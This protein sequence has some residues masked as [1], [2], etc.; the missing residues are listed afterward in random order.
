MDTSEAKSAWTGPPT[1]P[2]A[3]VPSA[4][5]SSRLSPSPPPPLR[6]PCLSAR[7]R[8]GSLEASRAVSF[9]R[10]GWPFSPHLCRKTGLQASQ[11]AESPT[12]VQQSGLQGGTEEA[13]GTPFPPPPP[14]PPDPRTHFFL[15]SKSAKT[16]GKVRTQCVFDPCAQARCFGTP[17]VRTGRLF[18]CTGAGVE[19]GR[20]PKTPSGT[21]NVRGGKR[22]VGTGPRRPPGG[23]GLLSEEAPC[24]AREFYGGPGAED[25]A[26]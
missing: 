17:W 26:A 24:E 21:Y 5:P 8:R 25:L 18:L 20:C 14:L 4:P 7:S 15:L 10:M 13:P 1:P 23:G 3:A 11:S 9:F 12:P 19:R 16:Q 2:G 6:V 22:P